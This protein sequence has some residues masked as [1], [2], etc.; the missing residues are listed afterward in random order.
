MTASI[1]VG[2]AGATGQ[3]INAENTR[4]ANQKEMNRVNGIINAI[5]DPS[6]DPTELTP[7]DYE[8]VAQYSPEMAQYVESVAPEIVKQ[9]QDMAMGRQAQRETLERL[10]G[11]ARSSGIDP[12]MQA[13]AN[14]AARR[15]QTEAQSRQRSVLQDAERR[16]QL[17]SAATVASQLLGASE[18]MDRASQNQNQLAMQAYQD[19][20]N[21]LSQSGQLGRQLAADDA[22]MQ[23]SNADVINRFNEMNTNRRQNYLNQSADATNQARLTNIGA[24]QDIANR[25]VA[26]RNQ[27]GQMN[28]QRA[29]DISQRQ[30]DNQMKKA[31]MRT[32]QSYQ[33]MQNNMQTGRDRNQA[34]QGAGDIASGYFQSQ[35]AQNSEKQ[36][37]DRE[38]RRETYRQTGAWS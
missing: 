7:E 9:S 11:I 27:Y 16:G 17:G 24:M 22:S 6:F 3:F 32:G 12:Q 36:R 10:S 37:Q 15:S 34:I 13:M 8:L 33:Q 23:R 2:G 5:Q 28:Q 19:R 29:D 31:A 38:D 35:A 4:R 18:S 1:L 20:L 30:Y 14:D 26:N 25:N 21:A